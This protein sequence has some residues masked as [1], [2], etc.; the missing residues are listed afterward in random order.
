MHTSQKV[1]KHRFITLDI[2]FKKVSGSFFLNP[3][4]CNWHDILHYCHLHI[5]VTLLLLTSSWKLQNITYIHVWN[6]NRARGII[7]SL[8][9]HGCRFEWIHLILTDMDAI[10]CSDN[11]E[12][13]IEFI[14]MSTCSIF[15]MF[16][17]KFPD[18][19]I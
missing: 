14:I 8:G 9:R 16:L 10:S 11:M 17:F 6:Q 13:P 19:I 5:F 1:S 3:N 12:N 7:Y 18:Y 15:T 4:A 2:N